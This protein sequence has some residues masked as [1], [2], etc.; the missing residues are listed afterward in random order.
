MALPDARFR[1][2]NR[3]DGRRPSMYARIGTNRSGEDNMPEH[4]EA[5]N[6][7]RE[8]NV[9]DLPSADSMS[10]ADAMAWLEPDATAR[11]A[12]IERALIKRHLKDGNLVLKGIA[13]G[14]ELPCDVPRAYF[15]APYRIDVVSNELRPLMPTDDRPV[16]KMLT[17]EP[18]AMRVLAEQLIAERRHDLRMSLFEKVKLRELGPDE[19]ETEATR[20]GVGP[21]NKDPD[22]VEFDPIKVARWSFAM[23]WAWLVW[24]RVDEV[25]HFWT[26][27][28]AKK[29]VWRLMT[30]PERQADGSTSPAWTMHLVP[31]TS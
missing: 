31:L 15:Y 4:P 18:F 3:D 9:N 24:G 10:V 14:E 27:W 6:E 16:Y 21:L 26:E 1:L 20:L 29:S 11:L 30:T 28:R 13:A 17:I 5:T 7:L 23:T 8:P 19:A 25:R 22:P 2:R 12:L